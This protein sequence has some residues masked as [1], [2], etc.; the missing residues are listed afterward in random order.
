M[1][2]QLFLTISCCKPIKQYHR[3]IY[4]IFLTKKLKKK[5]DFVEKIK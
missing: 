4:T 1:Y 3:L 5:S 2:K